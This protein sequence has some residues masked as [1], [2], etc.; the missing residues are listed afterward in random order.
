MITEMNNFPPGVLGFRISGTV[1]AD[2]FKIAK[3]RVEQA[4]EVH[5]K[6]NFLLVIDTSI[7]NLTPGA[8]IQDTIMGFSHLFQWEKVAMV[9]DQDG[10]RTFIDMFSLLVPG[11][12]RGF[13]MNELQDAIAWV[14][15]KSQDQ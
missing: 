7:A 2:D 11:E 8:W 10:V 15:E 9:S 6:I 4:L 13:A 1:T 3:A 5:D 12:Y 14:S